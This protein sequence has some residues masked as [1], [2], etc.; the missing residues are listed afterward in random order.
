MQTLDDYTLLY[1]KGE[2]G[3]TLPNGPAPG[4]LSNYSSDLAFSMERLANAP[5]S[6]RAVIPGLIPF[7]VDDAIATTVAGLT[8]AQLAAAGQL[9]YVDHSDQATLDT[10]KNMY[11]AAC[12]ALFYI[13]PNSGD[14]LPLAIKT[15]VG[16]NLVYTPQDSEH[17]W[18][19]AKIMFNV[20]DFFYHQ[21]WHLAATHEVIQIIWMA[22]IRTLGQNHP[23]YA[24][25]DRLTYQV[26]AIQPLAAAKLFATGGAFDQIFPYTG[27]A[28]QAYSSNLYYSGA[29]C[30]LTNYFQNDLSIRGLTDLTGKSVFKH[31]PYFEDA[32]VIYNAQRAFITAFVNSYYASDADILADT[33]IQA[34]ATEANGAAA[35]LDFTA[36]IL[37]RD[38]LVDVLTHI[39]HL[40]ST[41]H[42]TVNTNELITVSSTFPM[43]PAALHQTVPVI[44]NSTAPL[45]DFL[46]NLAG[47]LTQFQ[48]EGLL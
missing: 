14:F 31:F 38:T 29:G 42:H 44:K 32:S 6:L 41:V 28:A 25:M 17:D 10:T 30:I 1:Q 27:T 23:V 19:L 2:F 3:R 47:V 39:A 36:A 21:T 15:N 22:A 34:W 12:S 48:L 24:L 26:F 46:P 43:H 5:F 40:S 7:A 9:F 35:V 8:T 11:A 20:N 16:S 18:T 37:T 45:V 33:E 4:I 13:D